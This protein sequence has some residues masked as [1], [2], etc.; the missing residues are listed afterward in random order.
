M[1]TVGFLLT[2]VLS[3]LSGSI[4]FGFIFSNLKGVDITKL[5]SGNIGATNISR[6]FGLKWALLVGFL[7]VLKGAVPVYL[8]R[9][10]GYEG[11]YLSIICLSPIIGNA[12]S[13]W[14]N[15]KGGK[16]VSTTFGVILVLM[17]W[18]LSLVVL[19]VWFSLLYLI[20]LMSLTNLLLI[21]FSPYLLYSLYGP[22]L[23]IV[24]FSMIV[25]IWYTHRKN[26]ARLISGQEPFLFNRQ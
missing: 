11:W 6:V 23:A 17:G 22:K 2:V 19:L 20:N 25:M 14:L 15:F 9:Q 13:L 8:A 26:I 21:L 18:Q 1:T 5:G 16:A 12:F 4:P 10:Y 3:Y 24:G 7:D